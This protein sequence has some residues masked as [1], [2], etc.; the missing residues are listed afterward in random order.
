MTYREIIRDTDGTVLLETC[1]DK[2]FTD[3]EREAMREFALW[4]RDHLPKLT[5]EQ[6]ARQAASRERIRERTARLRGES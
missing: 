6:E 4:L 5:P 2:P 1:V 3:E